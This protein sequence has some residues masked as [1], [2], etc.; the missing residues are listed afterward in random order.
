[1]TLLLTRK[2]EVGAKIETTEGTVNPPTVAAE[3][4]QLIYEP[5]AAHEVRMF[6]RDPARV[7]L[8]TLDEIPG[9]RSG[10]LRFRSELRG[11]GVAT[12]APKWGVLLRGCGFREEKLSE[13]T[14]TAPKTGIFLQGESFTTTGGE[15]GV[16][17]Q[18]ADM[19]TATT[20]RYVL[21]TSS[22]DQPDPGDTIT[23]VTSG[24]TATVGGI[25]GA[26]IG[27]RYRPWSIDPQVDDVNG[28][29]FGPGSLTL[30]IMEDGVRKLFKGCRGNVNFT[31][32]VGEPG[33]MEFEFSGVEAGVSDVTFV[34][35]VVFD[36]TIPPKFMGTNI[37]TLALD[38]G[39]SPFNPLITSFSFNLN[40]EIAPRENANDAAGILSFKIPARNPSGTLDP[41]MNL[42]AEYDWFNKWFNGIAHR[43]DLVSLGTIA[44][45]KI[46]IIM[47]H[48]LFFSVAEA[49]RNK[50]DTNTLDFRLHSD[51]VNS[52][53]DDELFLVCT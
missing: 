41:E 51:S 48:L 45:N 33:F 32:N 37:L 35:G 14:V 27:F 26:Q 47:E 23:G 22:I 7:T 49:N 38:A 3:F 6:E 21:T 36:A 50:I 30:A 5:T 20:L 15:A 13:V 28:N 11:S 16:I 8:S 34:T 19:G 4:A 44:G 12:T 2:R 29:Y 31:M 1:M 10:S 52:F 24:A 46:D 17:H 53:G 40:S 18:N 9:I 25:A 43:L 42:V 39:T